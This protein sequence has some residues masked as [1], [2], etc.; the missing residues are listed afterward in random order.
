MTLADALNERVRALELTNERL[1]A[2]ADETADHVVQPADAEIVLRQALDVLSAPAA[3]DAARGLLRGE[4]IAAPDG[5]ATAGLV[6]WDPDSNTMRPTA[7]LA[8]VMKV[9]DR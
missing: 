3:M 4:E 6:T 7:L 1:R 9:V 5:L 8:E 2:L